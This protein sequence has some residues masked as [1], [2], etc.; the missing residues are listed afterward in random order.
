MAGFSQL[1]W[2]HSNGVVG[3]GNWTMLKDHSFFH[4]LR[5]RK[6]TL[7]LTMTSTKDAG[8]YKCVGTSPNGTNLTHLVYL[9]VKG[10]HIFI[11]I[12]NLESQS[13]THS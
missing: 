7:T 10:N 9:K 12:H 5:D 13:K 2:F 8:A 3:S 1:Q 11:P 4:E 6:Q